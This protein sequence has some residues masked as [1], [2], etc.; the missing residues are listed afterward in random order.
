MSQGY[1][2][3]KAFMKI[4]KGFFEGGPNWTVFEL[5]YEGFT[6]LTQGYL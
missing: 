2:I 5:I 1:P 4:H 6:A 3:K